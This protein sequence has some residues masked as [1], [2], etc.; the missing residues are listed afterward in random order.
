MNQF[1]CL[2]ALQC[3]IHLSML[4]CTVEGVIFSHNAVLYCYYTFQA[5]GARVRT[6]YGC[7]SGI[8]CDGKWESLH[9]SGDTND[10]VVLKIMFILVSPCAS[11]SLH[12]TM[13][14]PLWQRLC[15]CRCRHLA[16]WD[17][18][19]HI[20]TPCIRGRTNADPP[21]LCERAKTS[22]GWHHTSYG[23]FCGISDR[24]FTMILVC[25]CIAHGHVLR[26]AGSP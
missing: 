17:T 25:P 7:S 24:A 23:A 8:T 3:V 4:L 12:C 16:H 1:S 20:P 22:G 21:V 2:S 11:N 13:K 9:T 18:H 26:L 5:D 6:G 10:L 19:E 14:K 15:Q